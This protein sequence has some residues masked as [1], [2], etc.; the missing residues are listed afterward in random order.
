MIFVPVAVIAINSRLDAFERSISDNF[1]LLVIITCA[2]FILD[3]T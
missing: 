2:F 3:V 1:I